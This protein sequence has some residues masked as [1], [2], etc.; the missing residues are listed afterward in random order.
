MQH[1]LHTSIFFKND[2]RWRKL[3]FK[4][5]LNL[6]LQH[7]FHFT[8]CFFGHEACGILVPQ[9]GIKAASSALEGEVLT[10]GP[11]GTSPQYNLQ[12]SFCRILICFTFVIKFQNLRCLKP[13]KNNGS[14]DAQYY[15]FIN[16][17]SALRQKQTAAVVCQSQSC[18]AVSNPMD[19]SPPG[20][21]VHGIF[22]AKMLE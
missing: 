22:W 14:Y 9:P 3:I 10:T 4:S 5:S 8:F 21:F 12:Q 20:S 1:A 18:P 2:F 13:V 11:P 15:H 19:C 6:F 16:L 7:C 17:Q